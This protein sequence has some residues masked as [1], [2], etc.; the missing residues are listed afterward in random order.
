MV[1]SPP[2]TDWSV[3]NTRLNHRRMDPAVV[4]ERRRKARGHLEFVV[5]LYR[6]QRARGA[7]FLHEHP[8]SA[9][10]W[11]TDVVQDLLA[12]PGVQSAAGHMCRHG[13]RMMVPD[14]EVRPVRKPTRWA[15]SAPEVLRRVAL[16]CLNVGC[17]P[18]NP[19]WHQHVA[20][21]GSLPGGRAGRARPPATQRLCALSYCGV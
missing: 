7:H 15:S 6:R 5:E 21:E 9:D 20:L 18:G 12:E 14:G 2:C 10:S 3:L 16:R 19:G 4:A 11:D 8:A 17:R 13:M 1:G